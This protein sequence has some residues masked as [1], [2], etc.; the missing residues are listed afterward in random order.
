MAD[1]VKAHMCF[2]HNSLQFYFPLLTQLTA[3]LFLLHPHFFVL[4]GTTLW[5]VALSYLR[6]LQLCPGECLPM[7][8]RN[9]VPSCS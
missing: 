9:V 4:K 7:L 8:F 5:Q 6:K 2:P 1:R 3:G